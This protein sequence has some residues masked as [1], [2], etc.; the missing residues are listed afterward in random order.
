MKSK[1]IIGIAVLTAALVGT[2]NAA[3]LTTAAGQITGASANSAWGFLPAIAA[4]DESGMTGDLHAGAA[5]G[6]EW[7]VTVQGTT[8]WWAVEFDQAYPLANAWIWNSRWAEAGTTGF[9][10]TDV[11]YTPTGGGAEVFLDNFEF[12]IATGTDPI[13]H[14]TEIPFGGVM[15]EGVRFQQ[16]TDWGHPFGAGGLQEVRFNL[17]PEPSSI[18]ILGLGGLMM[19]LKRRRRA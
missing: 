1:V 2:A 12:A 4:A 14:Q 6:E 9:R 17:V 13:A 18:A 5:S 8:N 10:S 11:Y 3:Y 16:V 7:L 15:A 19:M